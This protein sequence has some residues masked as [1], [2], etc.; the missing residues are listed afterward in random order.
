[1]RLFLEALISMFPEKEAVMS[2]GSLNI[3]TEKRKKLA[4][5][6][7]NFE[8]DKCGPISNILK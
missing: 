8:C 5:E 7:W 3:S 4:K 6:S 2:V 1:M